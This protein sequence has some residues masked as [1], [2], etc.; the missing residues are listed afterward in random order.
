[1]GKPLK[2]LV[3]EDSEDDTMLLLRCLD[4]GGYDVQSRRVADAASLVAALAEDKWDVIFSDH[5]MP[6][7]N[8][9]EALEIVRARE[10]DIPFIIVSGSIGEEVAVAAMKAGAQ[11]YLIKGHFARLVAA[12]D[13]ELKDA[14]DRQGRR[15]AELSLLTQR[16]AMRIARE[17]QERLFPEH[18]PNIAGFDIA[19]ASRPAEATG[20]DYFDFIRGSRDET[21]VVIGDVSGHGLGS[22][23]LMADVRAY[24]RALLAEYESIP[25][26]L[27]RTSRLLRDDLGS[28]RFITLLFA[29]LLPATRILRYVNA[30]HPPGYV[31]DAN[32]D[33]KAELSPSVPALGLDPGDAFPAAVELSLAP[34]DLVLLMTDGA[35]ESAAES[36]EEFGVARI[37]D[38]VRRERRKPAAEI[39][40]ALFSAV[41]EF[42]EAS[43]LMDDLTAVVIK[44]GP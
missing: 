34:Q 30:G 18:P 8:S 2:V 36:G 40:Q 5:R 32:G 29:E 6:G 39:I 43:G 20:G 21:F 27:N 13:R 31:L 22:A 42:S 38:L 28:Y 11:D 15:K 23:L 25:D 14:E 10:T 1:M 19:G 16:E 44:V 9:T 33:I 26:V 4:R 3:I 35:V 17:V 12:V 7:F 24:L 37:L 41:G